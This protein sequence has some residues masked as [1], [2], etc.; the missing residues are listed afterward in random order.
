MTT[1][2]LV[3]LS[4]PWPHHL[5]PTTSAEK[6]LCPHNGDSQLADTVAI[7]CLCIS[8]GR[9]VASSLNPLW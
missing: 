2:A 3:A 8:S 1:L 6:L 4:L 9:L 5:A 7:Y